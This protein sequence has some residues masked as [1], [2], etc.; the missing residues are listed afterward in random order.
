MSKNDPRPTKAQFA[1]MSAHEK[2]LHTRPLMPP[3]EVDGEIQQLPYTTMTGAELAR[4]RQA[5]NLTPDQLAHDLGLRGK[6]RAKTILRWEAGDVKKHG[7]K[8]IVPGRVA[9]HVISI[10]V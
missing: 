8:A 9:A 7:H 6:S 2:R 10:G 3:V 4:A 5:A 1:A